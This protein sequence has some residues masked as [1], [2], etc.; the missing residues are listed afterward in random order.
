MGRH[1][2]S[3]DAPAAAMRFPGLWWPFAALTVGMIGASV[4]M[5]WHGT[6]APVAHAG[7]AVSVPRAIGVTS[8]P[9]AGPWAPIFD[10]SGVAPYDD[11]VPI[12]EGKI[13]GLTAATAVPR[14]TDVPINRG[15]RPAT[16]RTPSPQ[17]TP[18]P[19]GTPAPAGDGTFG[20]GCEQPGDP[21]RCRPVGLPPVEPEPEPQPDETPPAEEPAPD[22]VPVVDE[23]P[24]E[25]VE[26]EP[27]VDEPVVV[28]P[29]TDVA[30]P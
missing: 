20:D 29:V 9:A 26:E 28:E 14:R 11:V 16:S 25:S 12:D 2:H 30:A 7:D 22:P 19:P 13:P 6:W 4:G 23:P 15:T 24:T 27:P 1:W 17:P 10:W 18:V 8:A 5:I 21:V 3:D